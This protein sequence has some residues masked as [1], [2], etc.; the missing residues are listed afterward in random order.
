MWIKCKIEKEK[1][2]YYLR[3]YRSS[4]NDMVRVVVHTKTRKLLEPGI[5]ILSVNPKNGRVRPIRRTANRRVTKVFFTGIM[6]E[7][8]EMQG[9]TVLIY[10]TGKHF[11]SKLELIWGCSKI[12]TSKGLGEL[13]AYYH[14][15]YKTIFK[16]GQEENN[17]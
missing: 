3:H 14:K 1:D 6:K 16:G 5:I 10:K 15:L 17:V 9:D 11:D 8:Q 2:D 7:Y 4:N 12:P 13:D